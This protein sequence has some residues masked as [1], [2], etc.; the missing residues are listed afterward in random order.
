M[1]D[2]DYGDSVDSLRLGFD[3]GKD[4]R[5][6]H[7]LEASWDWAS[8]GPTTAQLLGPQW[9]SGNRIGQ[10]FSA[11]RFDNVYQWRVSIL[12]RDDPAMLQRKLALGR[13]V[14]NYGAIVWLRSQAVDRVTGSPGIGDGLGTNPQW[15]DGDNNSDSGVLHTGDA[16]GNGDLDAEGDSGIQ[17]YANLLVRRRAIVLTPDIWL[18]INW[19]T[20]RIELEAS[21]VIGRMQERDLGGNVNEASFAYQDVALTRADR[22]RF[23]QLGY[24]LEFKYGLFKDRFH[25]GLDHGFATG[26][27]TGTGD[28]ANAD[29]AAGGLDYNPQNPLIPGTDALWTNFRF[30]PAY[31]Q[32][33][34]LFRELLGTASNAAYFKPWLA[35]YFFEN[36]FSG[37]LDIEYAVGHQRFAT[38]GQKANYGLELDLSLRY[39]DQQEPIFFQLQY[40]VMFPFGAFNR[41]SGKYEGLLLP[42]NGDAKAAQTIQAQLGIRF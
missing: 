14:V 6:V 32:D 35:F 9:N 19:K 11:E 20:L 12:R 34:L 30:N 40:G 26:D 29:N 8:S 21:G 13:P 2:M 5:S 39:H 23:L 28:A 17:N 37:R 24:A 7:T 41:T 25:I 42:N 3:F 18:R 27:P 33:L 36:N 31:M 38:W 10:D 16:L 4:R 1:L 22:R 15:A